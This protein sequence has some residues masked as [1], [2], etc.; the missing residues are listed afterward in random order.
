[1]Q[2]AK[3]SSI[4]LQT[5][6]MTDLTE[7]SIDQSLTVD[8]E[9]AE[10]TDSQT[11]HLN[12]ASNISTNDSSPLESEISQSSFL[13]DEVKKVELFTKFD[14]SPE[15][16]WNYRD[17]ILS[18]MVDQLSRNQHFAKESEKGKTNSVRIR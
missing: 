1:M 9:Q 18:C 10:Q 5:N 17:L 16:T 3:Q 11:R 8:Q 15:K 2:S 4:S 12:Q 13:E 14:F 7:Q 6:E